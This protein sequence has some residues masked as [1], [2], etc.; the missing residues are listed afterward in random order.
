[1]DE[2]RNPNLALWHMTPKLWCFKNVE[3][4]NYLFFYFWFGLLFCRS[5]CNGFGEL[6]LVMERDH[7]CSMDN[8][9]GQCE[10]RF[11]WTM[12]A[13]LSREWGEVDKKKLY[14][15]SWEWEKGGIFFASGGETKFMFLLVRMCGICL[16]FHNNQLGTEVPLDFF[17][18]W[19]WCL[20]FHCAKNVRKEIGGL[21]FT[22]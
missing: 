15:A 13:E 21:V 5:L 17:F 19:T 1:M 8:L 14:E 6:D 20:I 10:S 12:S 9:Y 18:Y 7:G 11:L 3:K 2:R 16:D 4:F 22:S